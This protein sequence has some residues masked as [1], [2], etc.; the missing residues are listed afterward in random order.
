MAIIQTLASLAIASSRM[1][2]T[3]SLASGA[4]VRVSW[5]KDLTDDGLEW[6]QALGE[7]TLRK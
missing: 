1:V 4:L 3:S 7:I 5:Q 2:R 6:V